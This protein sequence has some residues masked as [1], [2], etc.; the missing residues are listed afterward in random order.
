MDEEHN[1]VLLLAAV[2]V[3][4]VL[5]SLLGIIALL[6]CI[7]QCSRYRDS[8]RRETLIRN[9]QL[10]RRARLSQINTEA[11]KATEHTPEVTEDTALHKVP[12][13]NYS[14][15]E[16]YPTDE[17]YDKEHHTYIRP[18]DSD[19]VFDNRSEPP[20]YESRIRMSVGSRPSLDSSVHSS[21]VHN[22]D[23]DQPLHMRIQTDRSQGELNAIEETN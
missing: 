10:N 21:S 2:S 6:L 13:P 19:D 9:R 5:L 17:N 7:F 20:G 1:L 3:S 15:V 22:L 12:P 8:Q 23:N 18:V 4:A 16:L 14:K 11:D